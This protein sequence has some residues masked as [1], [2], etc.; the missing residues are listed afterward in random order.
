MKK[1]ICIFTM[2][3]SILLFSQKKITKVDSI[4][5]KN[6]SVLKMGSK[7]K[8]STPANPTQY[9]TVFLGT[10]TKNTMS[11]FN[12]RMRSFMPLQYKNSEFTISDLLIYNVK[13]KEN[14]IINFADGEFKGFTF[15]ER[16]SINGEIEIK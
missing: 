13:G 8:V 4:V 16:S 10:F 12:L 7:I 6:G 11:N 3:F 9:Q 1:L 2:L 5:L 15:I 14:P